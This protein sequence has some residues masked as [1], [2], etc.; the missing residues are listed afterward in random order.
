MGD[1]YQGHCRKAGPLPTGGFS[2]MY[3]EDWCGAFEPGPKFKSEADLM[4]EEIEKLER[5][6]D[7]YDEL[8]SCVVLICWLRN[9]VSTD[10]R[11]E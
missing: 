1:T 5:I 6:A 11:R 10:R 3:G 9:L 4:R 7:H 8:V 2:P